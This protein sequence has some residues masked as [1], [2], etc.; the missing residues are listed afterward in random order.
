MEDLQDEID[1]RETIFY[2]RSDSW[3]YLVML[4]G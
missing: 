4:S 2:E 3:Q 1:K